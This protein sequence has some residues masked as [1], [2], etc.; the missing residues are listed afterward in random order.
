MKNK[1]RTITI[2]LDEGA[3]QLLE[4]VTESY[5][6]LTTP[7]QV[8]RQ[9]LIGGLVRLALSQSAS[10]SAEFVEKARKALKLDL[11]VSVAT[12]AMALE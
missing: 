10:P 4:A 9:A 3:A 7:T 6:N 12:W 2:Q 1:A 5:G 11:G 8:A